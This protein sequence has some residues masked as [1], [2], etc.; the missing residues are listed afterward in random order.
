MKDPDQDK[1]ISINDLKDM[2]LIA[3]S[4]RYSLDYD[5]I[6]SMLEVAALARKVFKI[7]GS[8]PMF[9][10]D[11]AYELVALRVQRCDD[12]LEACCEFVEELHNF[13]VARFRPAW[14]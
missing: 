1:Q 6:R 13:Y 8:M 10:A 12:P 4:Q 14:M 2:F 11:E 3:A 5:W 7:F 9:T